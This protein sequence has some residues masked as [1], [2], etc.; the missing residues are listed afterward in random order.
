[1]A[2]VNVSFQNDLLTAID[3]VA[4]SESRTRSE[5]LREAARVYIDRKHRWDRIFSYGKEQ[6]SAKKLKEVD[7]LREI[8]VYRRR[9]AKNQ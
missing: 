8:R 7:V 9:K 2:T 4:K 1:M 3:E 6:A 5:L